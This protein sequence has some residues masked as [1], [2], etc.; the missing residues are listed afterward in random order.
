MELVSQS[1]P[2]IPEE[3]AGCG[4]DIG[5][6]QSL[7]RQGMVKVLEELIFSPIVDPDAFSLPSF[8]ICL[9]SF[10]SCLSLGPVIQRRR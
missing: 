10:S 1:K 5:Q 3:T 6:E 2:V 9:V 8:S 4:W 7:E